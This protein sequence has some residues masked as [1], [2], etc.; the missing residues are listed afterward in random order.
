M[1]MLKEARTQA[2][3][4]KCACVC[5]TNGPQRQAGREHRDETG[6]H[7]GKRGDTKCKCEN[8]ED[9]ISLMLMEPDVGRGWGWFFLATVNWLQCVHGESRLG[10]QKPTNNHHHHHS[11]LLR[12]VSECVSGLRGVQYAPHAH[13]LFSTLITR[14]KEVKRPTS[15]YYSPS[16]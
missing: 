12:K 9:Q 11:C 15:T 3:F 10:K 2:H 7:P 4:A 1:Q 8:P 6:C 13:I 16:M 5:S 14:T